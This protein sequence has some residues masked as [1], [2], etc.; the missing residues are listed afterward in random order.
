M[1]INQKFD[2]VEGAFDTETGELI[3]VEKSKYAEVTLCFKENMHIPFA[4]IKLHSRDTFGEAKATMADAY[5]LGEEICKRWNA[6]KKKDESAHGSKP[7][8]QN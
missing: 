6:F 8:A 3:C 5:K 4:R 7:E 1:L 2:F